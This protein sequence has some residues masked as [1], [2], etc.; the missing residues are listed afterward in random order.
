[1]EV[2]KCVCEEP[3][4]NGDGRHVRGTPRDVPGRREPSEVALALNAPAN[5]RDDGG[6]PVRYR[7]FVTFR[8]PDHTPT[9]CTRNGSFPRRRN[10][11]VGK[12]LQRTCFSHKRLSE[13][14]P[15]QG[16]IGALNKTDEAV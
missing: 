13:N 4:N 2:N 14:G 16:D 15:S 7:D 12:T 8:T 11:V 5:D 10:P 3:D 9:I 1:M 6:R